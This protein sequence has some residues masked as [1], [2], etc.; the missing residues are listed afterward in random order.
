VTPDPPPEWFEARTA[1]LPPPI[2]A[3]GVVVPAHN[4]QAR[5]GPCLRALRAALHQL[6]P[7]VLG[8]ICLVLDRCADSTAQVVAETLTSADRW[9][10]VDV[11]DNH[12]PGVVARL[13]N[14]GVAQL[15]RRL[16][17]SPPRQTWLLSTDADSTVSPSWATDHLR[18]ADAGADAVAGMVGLDEPGQLDPRA[19]SRY[20]TVIE[21]GTSGAA[22]SHAWAANLG[23]RA[24]AYRAVGGFPPVVSGEEH[25][26]L[27]RLRAAGYQITSPTDVQVRTSARLDGRAT[28][29]LAELLRRLHT[30]P[31]S[32]P[33]P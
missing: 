24:D 13:R 25:A 15:T 1:L 18:Y 28:G 21:T 19:L 7:S 22:H 30:E 4:E 32:E 27:A 17:S 6:P 11:L 12:T 16:V 23:V 31:A 9:P 29:G 33:Q 26:L 10:I 14:R 20:T 2:R 5:I 3:V 8:A